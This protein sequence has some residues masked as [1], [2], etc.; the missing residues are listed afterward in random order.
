MGRWVLGEAYM[1]NEQTEAREL[2]GSLGPWTWCGDPAGSMQGR[3]SWPSTVLAQGHG[4]PSPP[5]GGGEKSPWHSQTLAKPLWRHNR[6]S[7]VLVNTMPDVIS[8]T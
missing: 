1:D 3:S 8:D 5:G 4:R 7:L 2:G 6:S